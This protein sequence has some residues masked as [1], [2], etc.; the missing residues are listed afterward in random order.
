ATEGVK[1]PLI[2]SAYNSLLAALHRLDQVAYA[3]AG[4]Q[5]TQFLSFSTNCSV[6]RSFAGTS[7]V[8]NGYIVIAAIPQAGEWDE[9]LGPSDD[10]CRLLAQMGVSGE[11]NQHIHEAEVTVDYIVPPRRILAAIGT[12]EHELD[13]LYLRDVDDGERLAIWK[14]DRDAGISA[15]LERQKHLRDCAVGA[16]WVVDGKA[17]IMV[18]E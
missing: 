1:P 15:E 2:A 12:R 8:P 17:A 11:A 18:T 9:Q 4:P 7:S 14:G 13:T 3:S 10:V 16:V 5:S 6:A